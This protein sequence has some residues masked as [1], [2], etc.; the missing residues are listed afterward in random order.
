MCEQHEIPLIP[1]FSLHTSLNKEQDK[2]KTMAEKYKINIA[3]M[4]IVWLLHKSEWILPIPGTTS[5]VHLEENLQAEQIS[6]SN[7][8]M[9]F[10]G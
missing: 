8:D 7:E 9:D 10:L 6:I 1:Y 5:V 3:Q 2:I 4:N